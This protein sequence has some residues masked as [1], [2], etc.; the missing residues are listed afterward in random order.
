LQES[1]HGTLFFEGE[2]GGTDFRFGHPSVEQ[3]S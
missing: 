1:D 3:I 2:V